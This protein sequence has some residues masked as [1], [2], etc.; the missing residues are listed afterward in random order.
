[1]KRADTEIELSSKTSL[2]F[3]VI[4]RNQGTLRVR[5][6]FTI[7]AQSEDNRTAED[8][9]MLNCLDS[10][11]QSH[12]WKAKQA[13]AKDNL[14]KANQSV[15]TGVTELKKEEKEM[16]RTYSDYL[17]RKRS[18]TTSSENTAS[19]GFRK[20]NSMGQITNDSTLAKSTIG[21]YHIP[22]HKRILMKVSKNL[23]SAAR[24]QEDKR[25][26][27]LTTNMNEIEQARHPS[28]AKNLPPTFTGLV[29]AV[30]PDQSK[31]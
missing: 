10:K 17:K 26:D 28:H 23:M 11:A 13:I 7:K 6:F 31:S 27:Y 5:N 19:R 2:L 20:D 25:V 15:R 22:Y 24:L 16:D 8:T 14:E 1:L 9:R 30:I 18:M 21:L 29:A 12:F 4:K 3:K